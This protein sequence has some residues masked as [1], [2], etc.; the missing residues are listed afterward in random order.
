[1]VEKG[2]AGDAPDG[3]N[4]ADSSGG[5]PPAGASGSAPDSG[6]PRHVRG[7]ERKALPLRLPPKLVAE[8]RKWAAQDLRSLNAQIEYLLADALR[9]RKGG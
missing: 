2:G 4:P 9:R 8:L 3:T 6:V 7:A 1:V 5:K